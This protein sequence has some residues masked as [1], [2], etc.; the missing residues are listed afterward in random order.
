[1]D[2]HEAGAVANMKKEYIKGYL[3]DEE[4]VGC[5]RYPICFD[6]PLKKCKEEK[7]PKRK[8]QMKEAAKRYRDSHKEQERERQRKWREKQ[9]LVKLLDQQRQSVISSDTKQ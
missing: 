7:T 6:C 5:E 3:L 9:R 1:M 8:Q 4:D 2:K